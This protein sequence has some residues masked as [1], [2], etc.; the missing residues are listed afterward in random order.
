MT[1][2]YVPTAA[3]LQQQPDQCIEGESVLR[4]LE[5]IYRVKALAISKR[6]F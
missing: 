4:G 1:L 3:R 6:T 2:G 5:T